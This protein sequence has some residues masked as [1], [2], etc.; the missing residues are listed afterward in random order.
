MREERTKDID[1]MNDYEDI[2]QVPLEPD[3]PLAGRQ[4]PPVGD[5]Y[6]GGRPRRDRVS[7]RKPGMGD[8]EP[9]ARKPAARTGQEK[10][11]NRRQEDRPRKTKK[12]GMQVQENAGKVLKKACPSWR[13][14]WCWCWA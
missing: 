3:R 8:R 10:T 14:C 11:D 4:N 5:S 6:I 13:F 1:G 2:R 7:R 9:Q 12:Q